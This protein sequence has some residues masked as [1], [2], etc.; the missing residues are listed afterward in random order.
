MKGGVNMN[1]ASI[2]Q[3]VVA[4]HNETIRNGNAAIEAVNA[5]TARVNNVGTEMQE[6]VVKPLERGGIIPTEK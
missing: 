5:A 1:L 2:I 4:A 3:A 6:T